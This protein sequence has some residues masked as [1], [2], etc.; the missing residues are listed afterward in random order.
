MD[1]D[2]ITIRDIAVRAGVSKTTVSRVLNDKP[3]VDDKTRKLI[4]DIIRETGFVPQMSAINLSRGKTGLIGLVVPS[5]TSSYSLT[6]IQGV[7]ET[8]AE[9][10]YELVLYT[11]SLAEKNQRQF[12]QRLT[13]NTTDGLV[14]LL[15]RNFEVYGAELA[16]SKVPIVLVD[17]RG[18][19]SAFPSVVAANRNGAR[20]A[21]AYLAG[22]GHRRIGFISGPMDFGCSRDRL[23][24]FKDALREADAAL[25]AELVTHG[26]FT[27]QSGHACALNLLRLPAAPTAIFCSNDEMALGAMAAVR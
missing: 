2:K 21:A 22:L 18:I 9:T 19:E 1:Y 8:I 12:A 16:H 25:P 24:G 17:H 27:R 7:A 5:L 13:K 23:D 4:L 26:D 6:V 14:I 20:Q 15:P 3:D 10:D 11:T